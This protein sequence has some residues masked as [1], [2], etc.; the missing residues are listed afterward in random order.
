MDSETSESAAASC[1]AF[2]C[3]TMMNGIRA[4]T[5][6]HNCCRRR[7]LRM[8]GACDTTVA[9]IKVSENQ[10]KRT[11][12]VKEDMV[13]DTSVLHQLAKKEKNKGTD[14][15]AHTHTHVRTHTHTY[16]H[17]THTP[18]KVCLL[19]MPTEHVLDST[20]CAGLRIVFTRLFLR[21]NQSTLG[22]LPC[23]NI[24]T[25]KETRTWQFTLRRLV[26]TRVISEGSA[27][28]SKH[29]GFAVDTANCQFLQAQRVYGGRCGCFAIS[30]TLAATVPAI[31]HKEVQ[32]CL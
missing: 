28:P 5:L 26:F 8:V 10:L 16:A 9:G 32:D 3:K 7:E 24:T 11:S 30:F 29:F 2:R 18:H 27:V 17:N 23:Q 12:L 19:G 22:R 13:H 25:G 4:G 20:G 1:F 21:P 14:T 31:S 6:T 15:E